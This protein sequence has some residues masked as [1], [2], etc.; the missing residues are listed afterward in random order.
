MNYSDIS[1][2][3]DR[4]YDE[5]DENIISVTYG[6]KTVN[7]VVTDQ[8]AII[9]TVKEK[10]PE[11][12]VE[13]VLPKRLSFNGIEIYTDVIQGKFKLLGIS[14]C[15][16]DFYT[17][18]TVAPLNRTPIR[19]LKGGVSCGNWDN[20]G[21]IHID[22]VGDIPMKYFVG[23]MG[24]L[25]KDNETNSLVGVTNNHVIIYDAFICSQRSPGG[26]NAS[27]VN[28]IKGNRV[29]QP[30][31]PGSYWGSGYSIGVVKRYYPIRTGVH[32][33]IDA[34]LI[35]IN[36]PSLVNSSSWNQLNLTPPPSYPWATTAEINSLPIGSILYSSGRT[37]GAKGEGTTKLRILSYGTVGSIPYNRQ[38]SDVNVSY[39]ECIFF[40]ATLN[41]T[42]A[43]GDTCYDPISGGDSGSALIAEIGGV[44]KII[45]L[46]FAG[47]S[48][49]TGKT[50]QGI[51]CRIDYIASLMNISEWNGESINYSNPSAT[52]ELAVD[53]LDDREYIDHTDGKR[54]W[55]VGLRNK[56]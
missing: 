52:L 45:G 24:L 2:L 14:D 40:V 32:N 36:N 4:L 13:H 27:M 25:A 3:L 28:N 50:V 53:G 11:D 42:G 8:E 9:F 56:A 6:F 31:E 29:V 51:A 54:Y 48:D 1:E 46:V 55:Q 44:K 17:W 10:L 19:P 21:L 5:T 43:I 39:N 34:A 15:D 18:R 7:G 16:P 35:A 20:E 41:P 23:T 47:S 12:K 30:N 38:G 22:G 26:T 49:Y 37:T 33:K